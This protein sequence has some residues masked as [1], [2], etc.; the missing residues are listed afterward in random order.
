MPPSSEN[1][2]ERHALAMVRCMQPDYFTSS[3]S[4]P[5]SAQSR[6]ASACQ[7]IE[8]PAWTVR[9][10]PIAIRW[11]ITLLVAVVTLGMTACSKS[12]EQ[13]LD[14]VR[15]LQSA[16]R[17]D[18]SIPILIELIEDG[19]RDG[20]ALY[21][22][23]RALSLTGRPGR[24]LW[25][26]DSALDDSDWFVRASH[27]IALNAY[28][29]KNQELTIE[30]LERLRRDR[31]DSHAEDLQ[32][33]LLELRVRVETRRQ[34]EESL[35]LAETIL[36]DYP[37][38]GEAIRL[39]AVALL[40]LKETDEAYELI[41][42]AGLL[43]SGFD[44]AVEGANLLVEDV[45]APKRSADAEG[46]PEISG[47]ETDLS[48]SDKQQDA[49]WCTVRAT[50]KREAGEADEAA[51]I[52]DECLGRFPAH[53][54]LINEAVK[55]FEEMERYDR[56]L[57]ILLKANK[58]EPGD[59]DLRFALVQYL[60]AIGDRPRAE[61]VLRESL[62]EAIES[63]EKDGGRSRSIIAKRW[64]D[65]G[66]YLVE[67]DKRKEALDAFDEALVILGDQASPGFLFQHA[68]ALILAER[69]DDALAIAER[70]P[71]EVHVPM[72]RGRV[73][74]ERNQ[75]ANAI[76]E[77]DK[78]ALL[79]PNNAPIRYY[80]ARSSEGIGDFDRAIE[81]YRQA[82]RSDPKL[83]AARER[84]A[85]L[86]LAE[87]RIRHAD[88]I[89][90][91]I[92]AR[93]S[94]TPSLEMSLLGIEVR[95]RLGRDLSL[96]LP[97]SNDHTPEEL[98]HRAVE[99][100]S[101]GLQLQSTQLLALRTL[102]AVEKTVD[103]ILRNM[104]MRERVSL[105]LALGQP[106]KAIKLAQ[107]RAAESPDDIDVALA[108]GRALVAKG[109]GLSEAKA[110]L[111]L[112]IDARPD[113]YQALASLGEIASQEGD[114]ETSLILYE[115]A[116]E[117]APIEWRVMQPLLER[118]D[119]EGE[120]ATALDR[121]RSFINKDNPY[122]GVAALELARRL[123]DDPETLGERTALAERAVRFSGGAEALDLLTQLNPEAAQDYKERLSQMLPER[124]PEM[125][126]AP[127]KESPVGEPAAG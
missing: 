5:S 12:Q 69:Y 83:S 8:T 72:I 59:R 123:G 77:L 47:S 62:D 17:I 7:K 68:D 114:A 82:I 1:E 110:L 41:R 14:E 109:A 98:R 23:G 80:L 33:L 115:R 6:H 84:L 53:K 78:A 45:G 27:Q 11:L 52:F 29:A 65:L 89:L 49:Y 86:H 16:G 4:F 108:L 10:A 28:R 118:L 20:E 93:E 117:L 95:A 106:D 9:P 112:V 32:A 24:G 30:T 113:E 57:E 48:E 46:Q 81:E 34:Y 19:N 18:E 101:R 42:E 90:S 104:I 50:F 60:G 39:K 31:T 54:G 71:V 22:Y 100:L 103:P 21:R 126:E 116:F 79:W 127:T 15:A 43:A 36:D 91:F 76:E 44:P 61:L 124:N 56:V 75:Y 94:S 64:V 37:D 25:A 35:E 70:T 119:D 26:L 120:S 51:E 63:S 73:A 74:F 99:S 122:S 87:G 66:G 107:R 55:L 111:N 102:V 85:K 105:L 13:I 88:A 96:L 38:E 2:V 3:S 125:D 40:G 121:L 92:S 97:S 58:D 67:Q